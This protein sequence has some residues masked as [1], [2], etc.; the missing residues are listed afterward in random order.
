[1][2]IIIQKVERAACETITEIHIVVA[3]LADA[4]LAQSGKLKVVHDDVFARI[5]DEEFVGRTDLIRTARDGRC[6]KRIVSFQNRP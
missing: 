6:G 5:E 3:R 4:S 2:D 1:M